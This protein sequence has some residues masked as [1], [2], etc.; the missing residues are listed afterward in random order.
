MERL[1]RA[2]AEI[3]PRVRHIHGRVGHTQGPQVADPRAPEAAAWLEL[4][5]RWWGRIFDAQ[6]R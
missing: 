1:D 2:V 3:T 5:L 6:V 4:A